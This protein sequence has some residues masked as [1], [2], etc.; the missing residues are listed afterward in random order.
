MVEIPVEARLD[1]VGTAQ[2]LGADIKEFLKANPIQNDL[3]AVTKPLSQSRLLEIVK[4]NIAKDEHL[5]EHQDQQ[6]GR[7]DREDLDEHFDP[8]PR[9]GR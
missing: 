6:K 4:Q 3:T 1:P 5:R 2:I 7:D 9:I 8:G